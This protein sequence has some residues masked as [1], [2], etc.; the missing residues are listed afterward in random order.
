MGGDVVIAKKGMT[1]AVFIGC[2]LLSGCSLLSSPVDLLRAP[3]QKA[4]EA[5]LLHIIEQE[6]PAQAKLTAPLRG[7]HGKPIEERDLD[8]DGFPETVVL[9]RSDRKQWSVNLMLLRYN[10]S[11]W[12]KFADLHHTAPDI[13]QIAF[14]DLTG[15][16]KPEMMVGWMGSDPTKKQLAVYSIDPDGLQLIKEVEYT[17]F[18]TGDVDGDG[19]DDVVV[20][21][22]DRERLHAQ[23]LVYQYRHEQ[24]RLVSKATLDGL[25][26]GFPQLLIGRAAEAKNGIFIV[27]GAGGHSSYTTLLIMDGNQLTDVIGQLMFDRQTE[28]TYNEILTT[29]QDINND[30]IIEISLLYRPPGYEDASV[31]DIPWIRRWHQW[32]GAAALVEVMENYMDENA[33]FRVDIPVGWKDKYTIHREG[34]SKAGLVRFAWFHPNRDE[35]VNLITIHYMPMNE[36]IY[37]EKMR[38]GMNQ[39]WE[40][41]GNREGIIYAA[42]IH[43]LPDLPELPE[44]MKS[45]IESMKQMMPDPAA[46]FQSFSTVR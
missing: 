14:R 16:G 21:T 18:S 2:L 46:M 34:N 32:D 9:Y 42:E 20:L 10:G 12:E 43:P 3:V 11:R 35:L 7:E 5:E 40:Q 22:L 44:E 1:L 41:L 36:W 26:K 8:G 27:S 30:G 37:Q 13:D 33:G 19:L 24:I 25:V 17:E 4:S 45:E 23:A 39:K 6:L 15:D 28:L 31:S 29:N 38:T